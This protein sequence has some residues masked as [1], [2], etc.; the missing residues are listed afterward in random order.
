MN[1]K[2]V[3]RRDVFGIHLNQPTGPL[4]RIFRNKGLVD[5]NI[6]DHVGGDQIEG[7]RFSVGLG[8]GEEDAVEHGLVISI[9]QSADNDEFTFLHTGTGRAFQHFTGVAIGRTTNGLCSDHRSDCIGI[10]LK[11]DQ[12]IH[13]L[14]SGRR[15]FG[16]NG[17]SFRYLLEDLHY[18][19]QFIQLARFYFH[20]I[21][22][23]GLITDR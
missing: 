20:L 18:N 8:T 2:R 16:R 12:G 11:S 6:I 22:R 15:S 1:V 23:L 7:E 19:V 14:F 13:R 17:N 9:G 10:T 3:G 4:T 21:H 5:D